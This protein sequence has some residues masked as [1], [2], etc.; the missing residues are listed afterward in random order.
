M[1]PE[2][3]P[4]DKQSGLSQETLA[5]IKNEEVQRFANKINRSNQCYRKIH[6]WTWGICFLIIFCGI[7][8][9]YWTARDE[10]RYRQLDLVQSSLHNKLVALNNTLV[11][12]SEL[13]ERRE[14]LINSCTNNNYEVKKDIYANRYAS[15]LKLEG[16]AWTAGVEFGDAFMEEV[17]SLVAL[18]P[19]DEDLCVVKAPLPSNELEAKIVAINQIMELSIKNDRDKIAAL[20]L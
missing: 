16:I 2:K 19:S 4:S 9:F 20:D 18:E 1:G 6:I 8:V 7:G 10:H 15:L 5:L 11:A 13:K 12:I 14:L 3:K 17:N